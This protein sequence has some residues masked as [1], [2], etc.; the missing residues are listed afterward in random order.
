[1]IL[2]QCNNLNTEDILQPATLQS[3]TKRHVVQGLEAIPDKL[4]LETSVST[5]KINNN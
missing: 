3:N 4:S 2:S 1:M 5:G